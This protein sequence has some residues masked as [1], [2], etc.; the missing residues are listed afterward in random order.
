MAM[1][2]MAVPGLVIG[3]AYIFFFNAKANPLGFIYATM[4]ILVVN[5]VTHLYTVAHLTAT[6]ALKAARTAS[7]RRCR[8]RSGC[9]WCGRCGA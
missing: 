4:I 7:S 2:P 3:L 1:L 9:R 8:P 6:T 5:S